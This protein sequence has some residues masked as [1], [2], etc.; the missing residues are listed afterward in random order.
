MSRPTSGAS[1][2]DDVSPSSLEVAMAR[3]PSLLPCFPGSAA[4]RASPERRLESV[5]NDEVPLL[6]SPSSAFSA[7]RS[8]RAFLLASSFFRRFAAFFSAR[9]SFSRPSFSTSSCLSLLSASAALLARS[10]LSTWM[11]S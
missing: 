7:F 10:F 11:T 8:S 6:S 9:A 5:R 4:S 1:G 2:S 3:L